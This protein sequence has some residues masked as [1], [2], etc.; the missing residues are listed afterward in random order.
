MAEINI[1]LSEIDNAIMKLQ[2]LKST[3]DGINT[4]PPD[5]VGGG[6]TVNEMEIISN[7]YKSINQDVSDLILNTIAFMSNLKSSYDSSDK[8]AAGK[9][10]N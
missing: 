10:N 7:C 5:T 3:C 8:K 6:K 1:K 2:S 4:Q 9:I